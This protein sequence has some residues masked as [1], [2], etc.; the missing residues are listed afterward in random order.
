[1][2]VCIYKLFISSDLQQKAGIKKCF[3]VVETKCLLVF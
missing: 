3:S 2:C 1:M